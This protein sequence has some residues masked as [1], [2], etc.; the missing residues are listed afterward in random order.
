[1]NL[2]LDDTYACNCLLYLFFFFYKALYCSYFPNTEKKLLQKK[3]R[4]ASA[5]GKSIDASKSPTDR[6]DVSTSTDDL[7]MCEF[8]SYMYIY[9]LHLKKFVTFIDWPPCPFLQIF[10]MSLFVFLK[11][12]FS[13][14]VNSIYIP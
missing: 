2:L 7:G 9:I 1:M 10:C 3:V 14:L 12:L 5:N 6:K 4:K 11:M 13:C 8:C